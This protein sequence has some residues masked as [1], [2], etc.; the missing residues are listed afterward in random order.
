MKRNIN[1]KFMF[2]SDIETRTEINRMNKKTNFIHKIYDNVDELIHI[3]DAIFQFIT[4]QEKNVNVY[5]FY[6]LFSIPLGYR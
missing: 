4:E 3:I 1:N 2:F 6:I 5:R